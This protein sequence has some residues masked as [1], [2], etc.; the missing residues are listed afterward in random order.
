MHSTEPFSLLQSF[1][2][3][4]KQ[5]LSVAVKAI[6]LKHSGSYCVEP[7][8]ELT[9]TTTIMA[10]RRTEAVFMFQRWWLSD[11]C[12][13]RNCYFYRKKKILKMPVTFWNANFV[14]CMTRTRRV[15]IFKVSGSDLQC[16]GGTQGQTSQLNVTEK[17]NS[18]EYLT[19]M[20]RI[21]FEVEFESSTFWSHWVTLIYCYLQHLNYFLHTL[22]LSLFYTNNLFF[23]FQVSMFQL[24]KFSTLHCPSIFGLY[25]VCCSWTIL[26][27]F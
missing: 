14:T 22:I 17:E 26:Y 12:M 15:G 7:T 25:F 24:F 4:R 27:H 10:R 1:S 8:T 13:D 9:K 3:F 19:W 23:I 21:Q 2:F 11:C 6:F 5:S 16:R 18:K 20:D